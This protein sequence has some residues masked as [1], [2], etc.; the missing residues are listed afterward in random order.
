[1][2]DEKRIIAK[3]ERRID[4]F[5]EAHPDQKDSIS[6]QT[7][8]EFIHMLELEAK[9]GK[10]EDQTMECADKS[11]YRVAC[12]M[13]PPDE[14]IAIWENLGNTCVWRGEANA[15]PLEYLKADNWHIFGVHYEDISN[16]MKFGHYINIMIDD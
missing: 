15:I 3:L 10:E 8:Q 5:V 11:L 2:I 13:F 9:Y 14:K 12:S 1:M 6:V 4:D 7:V 16:A